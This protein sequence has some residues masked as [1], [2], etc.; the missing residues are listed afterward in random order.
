MAKQHGTF[1]VV[2]EGQSTK[3]VHTDYGTKEPVGENIIP[4]QTTEADEPFGMTDER[5]DAVRYFE[6]K[7]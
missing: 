6:R 5:R 1:W 2:K 4:L 3:G 7:K